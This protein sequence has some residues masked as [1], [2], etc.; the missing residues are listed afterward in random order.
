MGGRGREGPALCL[1]GVKNT[2]FGSQGGVS[3]KGRPPPPWAQEEAAQVGVLQTQLPSCA[4]PP[5][6]SL[7]HTSPIGFLC[8]ASLGLSPHLSHRLPVVPSCGPELS[9]LP[10]TSLY[11]NLDIWPPIWF[12]HQ[13]TVVDPTPPPIHPPY[14]D[15]FV[16]TNG[17]GIAPRL[18]WFSYGTPTRRNPS[19]QPPERPGCTPGCLLSPSWLSAG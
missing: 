3:C 10:F 18:K 2:Q 9:S 6:D 14:S 11:G 5:L 16:V 13:V 1:Q 17:L 7:L 8:T 4:Q 12:G 19:C 15:L